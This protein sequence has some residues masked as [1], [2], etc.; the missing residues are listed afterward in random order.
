[1]TFAAP[2][3][4]VALGMLFFGLFVTFGGAGMAAAVKGLGQ[5]QD[6]DPVEVR[7]GRGSGRGGRAEASAMNFEKSRKLRRVR[8]DA[9]QRR[10]RSRH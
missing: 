5:E 7:P 3:D 8:H 6:S 10:R 9:R 4:L 2:V 1:M